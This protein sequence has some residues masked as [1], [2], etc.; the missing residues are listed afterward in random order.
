MSG[1]ARAPRLLGVV[2]SV[3]CAAGFVL[4]ARHQPLPHLPASLRGIAALGLGI[5]AYTVATVVL[6]E[7]WTLLLRSQSP[8]LPKELGYRSGALSQLANAF[9]PVRAG[10]AVRIGLVSAEDGGPSTRACFGVLVA[11]RSIDF[12]CHA[13]LLTTVLVCVFGPSLGHFGRVPAMALG[14]VLCIAGGALAWRAAVPLAARIEGRFP[15]FLGSVRKLRSGAGEVLALSAILWASEMVGWWA[16]SHAVGLDL[17]P[18]QA[19]FVFLVAAL[20]I[21]LPTGFGAIGTLDAGIAF[22][23]ST[24]GGGADHVLGYVLLL[25]MMFVMPS[26]GIACGLAILHLRRRHRS[27]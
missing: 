7:R 12:G 16:A 6:F 22:S 18:L 1:S 20:A 21:A 8:D 10:D 4:W 13:L 17:D 14:A 2:V 23:V 27:G 15:R 3:A 26:I 11:E 25:R 24:V 5:S 9:L 19:A